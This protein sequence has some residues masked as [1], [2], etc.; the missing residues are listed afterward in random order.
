M[1]APSLSSEINDLQEP[2]MGELVPPSQGSLSYPC[3]LTEDGWVN[4]A[5]GKPLA[6]RVTY[7]KPYVDSSE[8]EA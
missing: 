5:S 3:E 1:M 7:W 8:E 4:A 2:L 6:V